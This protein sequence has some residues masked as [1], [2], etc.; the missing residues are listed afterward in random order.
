[1]SAFSDELVDL[2]HRNNENDMFNQICDLK[3]KNAFLQKEN[4][5]LREALEWYADPKQ[6]EF[7]CAK[8]NY[9]TDLSEIAQKALRGE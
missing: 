3:E 6:L 5:L 1:M 2:F 8:E 9:L 7:F 4:A